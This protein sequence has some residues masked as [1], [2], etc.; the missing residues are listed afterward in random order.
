[1]PSA[2]ASFACCE[3]CASLTPAGLA[4]GGPGGPGSG[5][6]GGAGETGA[7]ARRRLLKA[8]VFRPQSGPEDITLTQAYRSKAG[9]G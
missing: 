2:P 8:A 1:M 3:R 4:G 9:F 6:G 5:P 7:A